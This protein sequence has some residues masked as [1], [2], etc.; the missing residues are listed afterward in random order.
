[1]ILFYYLV[2][3]LGTSQVLRHMLKTDE[4]I[5]QSWAMFTAVFTMLLSI[6]WSVWFVI[7]TIIGFFGG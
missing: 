4:T 6:L 1:M 7:S 5:L 2:F 3:T